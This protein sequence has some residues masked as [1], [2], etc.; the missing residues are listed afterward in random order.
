MNKINYNYS[1]SGPKFAWVPTPAGY[2]GY[3]QL[4]EW[5]TQI[6]DDE[7]VMLSAP[8]E[9]QDRT[10]EEEKEEDKFDP[11]LKQPRY[12]RK[13]KWAEQLKDFAQ[14]NRHE[15]LSLAL[16]KVSDMLHKIKLRSPKLQTTI[17]DFFTSC[18]IAKLY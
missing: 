10:K 6:I 3:S 14:F 15:E 12:K 2:A 16:S 18:W 5:P 4:E 9:K 11:E 7:D 8:A 1:R 13:R 17:T